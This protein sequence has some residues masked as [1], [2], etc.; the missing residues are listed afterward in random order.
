G[1]SKRHRRV[2]DAEYRS[3]TIADL[4]E[5]DGGLDGVDDQ[6]HEVVGA[7]G[8]PLERVEGA[9]GGGAVPRGAEATDALGQRLTEARIE[10]EQIARPLLVGDEIVDAHDD[11][12]L[13]PDLA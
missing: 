13:V 7:A 11:P 3:Q 9:A 1:P 5:G 8:A 2:V 10:L 6:G 4:A 12:P